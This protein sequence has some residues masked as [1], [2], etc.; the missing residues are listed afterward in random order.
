MGTKKDYLNTSNYKHSKE[1]KKLI[2]KQL[3]Q[4]KSKSSSKVKNYLFELVRSKG[5]N[6]K[7]EKI[8]KKYY[9]PKKGY[10]FRIG[11]DDPIVPPKIW[12]D[13]LKSKNN[14][15]N[16][17]YGFYGEVKQLSIDIGIH[18]YEWDLDHYVF[19]NELHKP[20]QLSSSDEIHLCKISDVPERLSNRIGKEIFDLDNTIYPIVIRISPYASKRDILNF[21][22]KRYAEE[23]GPLREKYKKKEIKIGKYRRKSPIIQKRNDLIYKNRHKS[24]KEIKEELKSKLGDITGYAEIRKIISL[25]N[26]RRK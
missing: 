13:K 25:E 21:I 23:I 1:M 26:K 20:S 19:F 6:D 15:M 12:L 2:K 17:W 11:I 8:R 7:V 22:E 16:D 5:F 10:K 4:N 3:E 24:T 18:P 9:I 14:D